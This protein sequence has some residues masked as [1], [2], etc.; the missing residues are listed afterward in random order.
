MRF[1]K[2]EEFLR[3]KIPM[4]KYFARVHS[5]TLL[6][7]EPG[8][9]VL[10]IGCGT[11]SL[12]VQLA[13]LG[14]R[15]TAIDNVREAVVLTEKNLVKHGQRALL[16]HGYAPKDLP[17]DTVFDRCFIGGTRGRMK[18]LF[19]YLDQHLVSG[20][21]VVGNCIM[22]KSVEAFRRELKEY[23]YQDVSVEL[24]E[25]AKEDSIGLIRAEN[26]IFIIKGVK[27]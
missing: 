17:T 10:D 19:E 20:G 16:F 26:P 8:H 25:Y 7:V 4:T 9:R 15:V 21:I 12:T 6:E 2:D 24:M 11:G 13:M 27:K 18:E 1:L 22:L 3:E 14:A 5:S 23:E